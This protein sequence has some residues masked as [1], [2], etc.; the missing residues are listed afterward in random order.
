MR[1]LEKVAKVT[2]KALGRTPDEVLLVLDANTGQNAVRQAEE[3]LKSAGVTGI[4][5]SKVDG[6]SKGGALI[7]VFEKFQTPV[8]LVG[9]GEKVSDLEDFDA[10]QFAARLF[11]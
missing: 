10:V 6:T 5:L 3:F 1:E 11:D 4:V 8:K 9:T 7:E 2:E